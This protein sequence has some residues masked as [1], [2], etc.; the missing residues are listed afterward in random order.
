METTNSKSHFYSIIYDDPGA[1]ININFKK[2]SLPEIFCNFFEYK[3]ML[4]FFI[5]FLN[6]VYFNRIKS[7]PLSIQFINYDLYFLYYPTGRLH[8]FGISEK[9]IY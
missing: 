8:V 5:I 2:L 1:P 9:V 3:L 4:Q 7:F 6:L